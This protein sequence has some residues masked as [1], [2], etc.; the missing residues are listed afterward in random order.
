MANV[1]EI[2]A[3]ETN[4]TEDIILE[5]TEMRTQL[6]IIELETQVAHLTGM[7]T[8][9]LLYMNSIEQLAMQYAGEP[10]LKKEVTASHTNN[11]M[12]LTGR[13]SLIS[14]MDELG[15]ALPDSIAK[16]TGTAGI[17]INNA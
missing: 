3:E 5:A 15:I 16:K 13:R 9:L 8:E 2:M 7:M 12:T 14:K 11:G 1:G 10:V 17:T 4:E 6:G